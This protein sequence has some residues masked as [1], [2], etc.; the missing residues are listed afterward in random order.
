MAS[1]L[2]LLNVKLELQSWFVSLLILRSNLS[3]PAILTVRKLI[4]ENK[5]DV[6][7]LPLLR[8][9]DLFRTIY[10]EV[11][12]LIIH[13]LLLLHDSKVVLVREMAL[14]TP[15]HNRDF[16]KLNLLLLVQLNLEFIIF[17]PVPLLDMHI[18]FAIN[19]V[20]HI[21]DPRLMGEVGVLPQ[22][23]IGLLGVSHHGLAA[24]VNLTKNNLVLDVL[25]RV[26]F[27]V[28]D[29]VVLLVHPDSVELVLLHAVRNHV[30][31]EAVEGL[32]LLVNDTILVKVGI[33]D[34]PL[35]VNRN[36]LIAVVL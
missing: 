35:V 36:V 4:I 22:L 20:G 15:D 18:D 26:L 7:S 10:N 12:A 27:D 11:T 32:N 3:I 17:V 5:N 19:L 31:Y 34:L 24:G 33:D 9:N 28:D 14:R 1:F 16:A 30:L 25:L 23:H 8:N 2:P 21:P 13:A 6:T 29:I